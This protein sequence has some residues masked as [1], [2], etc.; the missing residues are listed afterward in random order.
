[1]CL[2]WHGCCYEY[3]YY[4]EGVGANASWNHACLSFAYDPFIA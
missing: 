3:C 4:Y 2:V 1:L